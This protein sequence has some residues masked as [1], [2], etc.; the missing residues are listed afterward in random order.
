MAMSK[1]TYVA[2]ESQNIAHPLKFI[3]AKFHDQI[4]IG[5]PS[6]SMS[7]E[8]IPFGNGIFALMR[9]PQL[10]AGLLV[11]IMISVVDIAN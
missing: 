11:L 1:L 10:T 9:S 4:C 2:Q 8:T 5:R 3:C 7:C 6:K